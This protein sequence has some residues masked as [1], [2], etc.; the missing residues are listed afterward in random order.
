MRRST[1]ISNDTVSLVEYKKA[2]DYFIY[3]NWLDTGTQNGFN[4]IHVTTFEDFQAREIRQ[5]FFAM[6]LLVGSGEIIGAV[7]ISPPETEAD[8]AIWI[9]SQYRRQGYGTSAF[10]LATKYAVE[11]LGISELHAGSYQDN[12]GSQKILAACGFVPNPSGSIREKH[13]LSGADIIQMDYL[14]KPIIIRLATPE[15]APAMAEVHMRSWEVAYKDIIPSEYIRE[16]NSTR[17]DMWKKN[18]EEGQ[19]P[20]RVILFERKIIGIMCFGAPQDHDVGEDTWELHY[21]YLHPD[22]FRRGIGTQAMNYAFDSS[23]DLGK[24]LMNVWVLAENTSSIKFY[25][26]CGF[27]ADGKNKTLDYGKLLDGIRMRKDMTK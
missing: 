8:L 2:D 11:V 4:G 13:Y 6:I 22:Y 25:E 10:A 21:I 9:Y 3:K 5:R 15:D 18:L 12:I 19:Y 17:P 1:Y 26:Q 16:K 23:K 27:V 14:Y 20:H 7:G 24:K